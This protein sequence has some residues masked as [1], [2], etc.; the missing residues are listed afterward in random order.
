MV[1][2]DIIS[3]I[4]TNKY[5]VSETPISSSLLCSSLLRL[6]QCASA[7]PPILLEY[8]RPLFNTCSTTRNN[9]I[10]AFKQ[11]IYY[12]PQ[13]PNATYGF[14][15]VSINQG[16]RVYWWMENCRFMNWNGDQSDQVRHLQH[17]T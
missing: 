16:E 10:R 1:L 9:H 4:L 8:S 13:Q 11:F 17:Q 2:D 3:R 5:W 15:N 14:L 7:Y 6:T 12:N